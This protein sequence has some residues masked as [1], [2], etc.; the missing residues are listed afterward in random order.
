M[1]LGLDLIIYAAKMLIFIGDVTIFIFSLL[2]RTIRLIPQLLSKTKN[3]S[4]TYIS[5]LGKKLK[6]RR[7]RIVEREI[8][9]SYIGF[10]RFEKSKLSK[11]KLPKFKLP[12]IKM[13]RVIPNIEP[14]HVAIPH[15]KL[16]HKKRGRK[17][18]LPIFIPKTAKFK[19][20]VVGA[21]I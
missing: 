10:P 5:Q 16:R 18:I 13:P 17:R 21:F 11:I 3:V 2:L 8:Y 15:V 6:I 7:N 14:P 19:Y 4:D 12:S 20:L 1:K 9:S